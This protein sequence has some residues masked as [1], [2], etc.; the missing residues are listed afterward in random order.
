MDITNQYTTKIQCQD[1]H[2]RKTCSKM[3]T[4]INEKLYTIQSIA[5]SKQFANIDGRIDE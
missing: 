3:R 5:V 1:K 4:A 2:H